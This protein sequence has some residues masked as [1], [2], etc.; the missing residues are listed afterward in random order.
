VSFA[1]A[2]LLFVPADAERFVDSALKHRPEA[3]ILDLEDGVAQSAKPAA[4]AAIAGSQRR[5]KAAGIDVVVR[6]SGGLPDMVHDLAALDLEALDAV[7][8]AKASDERPLLNAAEILAAAGPRRPGLIAL[9]ESPAALP[10]LERIAS[11]PGLVGMMFGPED[12]AA[13][14]GVSPDA[15]GLA[16]PATLVA[17]AC[18]GRGLFA[19]GLAGSLAGFRDLDAYAAKV[20]H[21]RSLGFT[22][23]AAIHPAQLPVLRAGFR[24]GEADIARARRIVEAFDAATGRGNGAV[25]LDGAMIDAPVAARARAL[26]AR[27]GAA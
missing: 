4:R 26:L 9:V 21:A 25:A 15:G 6:I 7:M 11:V 17:A 14:L 5:L 18:A 2:A 8:V 19:I 12:Y 22:G 16:V 20:A 27:A 13:E 10:R 24:P 23:A 3:V 1:W